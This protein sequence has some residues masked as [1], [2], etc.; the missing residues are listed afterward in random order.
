MLGIPT[1]RNF[2][3]SNIRVVDVPVLVQATEIHPS[4]PLDGLTL[5]N[6]TGTCSKGISLANVKHAVL[7]HIDVTGFER[8]LLS[9]Y[10]TTG[11]GLENAVALPAPKVPDAIPAPAQP[12]IL[13]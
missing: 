13:H 11:T 8:P 3:F 6:I 1:I 10:N 4:K 12:Y 9:T 2:S 7:R 5:S